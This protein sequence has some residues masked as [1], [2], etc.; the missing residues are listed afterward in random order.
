MKH[1]V[2]PASMLFAGNPSMKLMDVT[3]GYPPKLPS[4]QMLPP[5]GGRGGVDD[6]EEQQPMDIA[7]DIRAEDISSILRP[8]SFSP[9][10][11]STQPLLSLQDE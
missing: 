8:T 6:E 1:E 7:V 10:D 3:A 4:M 11:A 5:Q 2:L 9:P